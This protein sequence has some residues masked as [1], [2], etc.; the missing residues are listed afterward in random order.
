MAS[1]AAAAAA[2]A[3]ASAPPSHSSPACRQVRSELL[4]LLLDPEA[5]VVSTL[6]LNRLATYTYHQDGAG[7][8]DGDLLEALVGALGEVLSGPA[9]SSA[10]S[11]ASAS[12]ASPLALAKSLAVL[13][14]M[15]LHGSDRVLQEA[16]AGLGRA[17][18]ALRGYNTVLMAHRQPAGLAALA[19][20]V[21]GGGVD[22]GGPVRAAA[23]R[24]AR[25]W[26]DPDRYRELRSRAADPGS[27][28]PVGSASRAGFVAD[29]A[30]L[31][32]LRRRV[33]L[34]AAS[35]VQS[36][37]QK[38]EGGFGSGYNSRDGR[39][40]VGAAHGIEEMIRRAEREKRRFQDD[41]SR[42]G[43]MPKVDGRGDLLPAFATAAAAAA[44]EFS[45][46]RAPALLDSTLAPAPA[47]HHEEA[48]LL[49]FGAPAASNGPPDD[50]LLL[51]P[52]PPSSSFSFDGGD[53]GDLLGMGPAPSARPSLL[54]LAPPASA[55]PPSPD[56]AVAGGA[57][58][59]FATTTSSMSTAVASNHHEWLGLAT[60]GGGGAAGAA[61]LLAGPF[62]PA[63]TAQPP[64]PRSLDAM[65]GSI[66]LSGPSAPSSPG[67][68]A[69]AGADRFAAL[70]ALAEEGRRPEGSSPWSQ[71]YAHQPQR[72]PPL[73]PSLVAAAA[74]PQNSTSSGGA[75]GSQL[76]GGGG[77]GAWGASGRGPAEDA[78]PGG[79]F[80]MGGPAGTGLFPLGPA[81]S[82]PP[83]P[84]PPP[85]S[86]FSFF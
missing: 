5:E 56:W 35:T 4:G 2:W 85:S 37:L 42:P 75:A 21:K 40:V 61:P 31:R 65:L 19:L 69:S 82:A 73:A 29:E 47:P 74:G 9:S 45:E 54:D 62:S 32:A 33:E 27:L 49:D 8:G 1:A 64:P 63:A 72:A 13:E 48:D 3:T 28:V 26:S 18:E 84:P 78:P 50:L 81:P 20:R 25:L 15:L 24:V 52:G 68:R 17:V 53:Q 76:F 10:A 12:T 44:P 83:P 66:S 22:R 46:Y 16:R 55:T 79:G 39:A 36:N 11:I 59:S 6:E 80:V 14:W 67:R 60:I 70:D 30:R 34:E 77:T 51:P 41:G 57:A 58:S 71:G 7:A 86:S 38:P 23:D 43:Q